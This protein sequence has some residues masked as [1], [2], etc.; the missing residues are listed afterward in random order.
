[1]DVAIIV[2]GNETSLSDG[3]ICRLDKWDGLG[4]NVITRLSSQGPQ[5]RGDTDRGFKTQPRFVTLVFIVVGVG[6]AGLLPEEDLDNKRKALLR[7]VRATNVGCTL[8]FTKQSGD[9]KY[10]DVEYVNSDVSDR[11]ARAKEK[12]GVTFK[13]SEPDFY[14]LPGDAVTFGQSGGDD[15]FVVPIVV[16]MAV[17]SDV[18]SETHNIE[19][20]GS[21]PTFP[22]IRI[23]GPIEDALLENLSTGKTIFFEGITI[24]ADDY[25][26]IDLRYGY[27]QALDQDGDY[28]QV[29]ED[30][31]LA[32]FAIVP[33]PEA[34]DGINQLKISGTNVTS[35]TQA[36]M[37][38]IVRDEEL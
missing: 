36:D 38:W 4:L 3:A 27:K 32:D 30:S 28:V 1:M 17:G 35:A 33:D 16:P 26:D 11:F 19:Y 23:T 12:V 15:E 8:K 14:L 22:S 9:V 7:L 24:D 34:P 18:L 13:A 31:D 25:V 29:S 37:S 6:G 5:Q 10:L 20:E 21:A 2:A